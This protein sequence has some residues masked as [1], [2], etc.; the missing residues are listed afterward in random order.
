MRI[1]RIEKRVERMKSL[2]WLKVPDEDEGKEKK[3][4]EAEERKRKEKDEKEK[5]KQQLL[6][7][8]AVPGGMLEMGVSR[9]KRL[10]PKDSDGQKPKPNRA[11]SKWH[12]FGDKL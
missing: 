2:E 3:K 1:K 5:L 9:G 12:P 4:K 11:S 7:R 8:K 6:V 10:L